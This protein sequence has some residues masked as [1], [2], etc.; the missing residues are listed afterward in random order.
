MEYVFVD[1]EMNQIDYTHSEEL[2]I[3]KN[4]IIEIGAVRL[5]DT[6]Q[7]TDAFKTYVRP[8]ITPVTERITELTGI[9]NNMVEDAPDYAEAMDMFIGW[10]KDA[11]VIY[12]WSEND[13]RQLNREKKL[14]SYENPALPGLT[15]RWRDFQKEFA[16]MLGTKRR[17]A[18]SD[19]VFYLGEDFQG[20]EHDAL[21]DARNTAEV[22][23]LSKDE[24]K[25]RK[26]MAPIMEIYKPSKNMTYSI[27]DVF[28]N[29]KLEGK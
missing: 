10:C 24:E 1:F 18:L 15:G 14:K 5:N 12:A 11:D 26:I 23:V 16:R 19:A 9:T 20:E 2:K 8:V 3:C 22:F 27:G 4:E 13:L 7:E 25:F 17:I 28:K 6:Y 21:W 29:I